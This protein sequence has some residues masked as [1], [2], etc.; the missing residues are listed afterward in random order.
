MLFGLIGAG[1]TTIARELE[2]TGAIRLSLDEWT[3]AASGDRVHLDR[4]IEHRITDQ[5]MRLWPRP[6]AAGCDV[7]LDFGFWERPLRDQVRAAAKATGSETEL[8]WV[9]CDDTQRRRR[10][11]ERSNDE[12]DA[13]AVDADDSPGS[14]PTD[15]STHPQTMNLTESSIP[16]SSGPHRSIAASASPFGTRRFRRTA[17]RSSHR[18]ASCD[19]ESGDRPYVGH[20]S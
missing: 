12:L 8:I 6:I 9:Q 5:L 14:T 18:R 16:A 10:V 1:K 15:T 11:L 20:R 2:A 4:Q 7:V 3:I 17:W 19:R 13:Y